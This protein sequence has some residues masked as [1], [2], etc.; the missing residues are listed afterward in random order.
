MTVSKIYSWYEQSFPKGEHVWE[1]KVR[2]FR[3][4]A[5]G[6]KVFVD[7][8]L[9]LRARNPKLQYLIPKTF[10]HELSG[11]YE[12]DEDWLRLKN[13]KRKY[14]MKWAELDFFAGA[15][16]AVTAM[17]ALFNFVEAVLI[18]ETWYLLVPS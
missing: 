7:I 17:L 12:S 5:L 4:G 8:S 18:Y 2:D 10:E 11:F 13:S 16:S 9:A 6:A 3:D 1:F 14:I 15:I